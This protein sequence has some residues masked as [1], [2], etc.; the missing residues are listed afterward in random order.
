[1]TIEI[2]KVHLY[3]AGVFVVQFLLIA[4]YLGWFSDMSVLPSAPKPD[5][6]S[7][8]T[9]DECDRVR[10]A[11]DTV[12]DNVE[13]YRTIG[14]A[15]EAILA[16]VPQ[17]PRDVRPIIKAAITIRELSGLTEELQD[18]VRNLPHKETY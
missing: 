3:W 7:V 12:L 18:I 2:K 15:I 1:M 9:A 6:L 13:H 16:E 11:I 4:W 5:V 17:K 8:L 14:E 10:D